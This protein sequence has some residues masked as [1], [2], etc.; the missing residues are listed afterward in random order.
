MTKRNFDGLN[1]TLIH[2]LKK[3]IGELNDEKEKLK[4]IFDNANDGILVADMESKKFYT[5][6]KTICKML[7]YSL[8]K[9]KNLGILDIHSKKDLPHVMSQFKL[10]SM[11]KIGVAKD[12][13]VKRKDGSIFYADINSSPIIINERPC[14]LGI[15]RDVTEKKKAEEA[16][17]EEKERYAQLFEQS[18]DAIILTTMEGRMFG[19]NKKFEEMTG[20]SEKEIINKRIVEFMPPTERQ[21]NK[22]KFIECIKKGEIEFD[23]RTLTKT[24]GFREMNIKAKVL[25]IN[26]KPFIQAIARDVTEKKKAEEALKEN[27]EKYRILIENTT[28]M[29]YM[30]D[31]NNKVLSLNKSAARLFGKKSKEIAG[32]SLFK[33]FPKQIAAHFVKGIQTT[34]KTGK[35]QIS[36][37]KMIAKGKERWISANLSPITSEGKIVAVMGIT[38]DLTERRK[39]EEKLRQTITELKRKRN[40]KNVR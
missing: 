3:K 10:Q 25:N 20:F 4:V 17:K 14:L 15:F 26:G 30:I 36:E 11:K 35:N 39:I 32:S 8:G 12:I 34:F 7:G 16:L 21:K 24:R 2:Q 27:E 31:K 38:R 29:I 40:V 5:G 28:D 37:T 33:L 1:A 13:P 9:L 18:N 19:A 23:T 22:Y 6:N